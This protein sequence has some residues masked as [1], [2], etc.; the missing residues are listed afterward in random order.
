MV[1]LSTSEGMGFMI[2]LSKRLLDRIGL[3]IDI[4]HLPA[5]RAL[6]NANEG[7]ENGVYVRIQ[8]LE[9]EDKKSENCAGKNKRV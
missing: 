2:R 1:F 7:I 4:V 6:L 9:S 3:Q 8:G 5:E